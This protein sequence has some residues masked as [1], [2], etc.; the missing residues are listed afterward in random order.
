MTTD[1]R[2]TEALAQFVESRE[3][4]SSPTPIYPERFG[5]MTAVM[6]DDSTL[7][8]IRGALSDQ[9]MAPI[10]RLGLAEWRNDPQLAADAATKLWA[11]DRA[12]RVLGIDS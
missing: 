1:H 9:F 8:T 3:G 11:I 4:K 2:F 10:A 5:T 6:L 12:C 7:E